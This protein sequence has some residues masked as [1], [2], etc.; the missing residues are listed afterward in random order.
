MPAKMPAP[1]LAPLLPPLLLLAAVL[2]LAGCAT[3]DH[4]P[5]M[6]RL[7]AATLQSAPLASADEAGGA[8]PAENWWHDLGDAQLDALVAEAQAGSPSLQAALARVRLADAQ[9]AAI[10]GS[11]APALSANGEA[12]HQ[13]FS[14]HHLVPRP[15]AGTWQT[16]ARLALDLN[17]EIDFWGRS[18]TQLAAA[19]A[20]GEAARIEA[21]AAR[22]LL[23]VAI[24]R[25]Y[26]SY[27]QA[28]DEL[29]LA[30]A[31]A[32]RRE[33]IAR[34]LAVRVG[35][36]LAGEAELRTARSALATQTTGVAASRNRLQA[37]RHQLAALAGQGPERGQRLEPPRL[38]EDA[39]LRLPASLPADLLARRP[40]LQA[41]RLRAE[42]AAA[43]VGAARAAFY[44]NVNLLAFAGFQSLGLSHLLDAGSH[45]AGIG[46]AIHLPLFDG[47]RLQA[48][49][50]ARRAEYAQAVA[51]YNATLVDALRDLADQLAAARA[52]TERLAGSRQA[53]AEAEA[54]EELVTT[55]QRAGLAG[56]LDV[57]AANGPVLDARRRLA[58][59]RAEQLA[60]LAGVTRA[61]G[62]GLPAPTQA[63]PRSE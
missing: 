56:R 5:A 18:G 54:A 22:Q 38:P 20:R 52:A 2:S 29:A 37:L 58:E 43:E 47:G 35:A 62:G 40:D 32:T 61:L 46:P 50:D 44:P 12:I 49:L 57:L 39:P 25:S 42:A 36:G 26:A 17:Y 7:D 3:P 53:L 15:F 9:V 48:G 4:G 34:L 11:R 6:H 24:V 14:E 30:E 1:R 55:R 41:Q 60:A 59:A 28:S 16:T 8:W 23:A 13:R 63:A 21:A 45:I 27:A 31:E 33:D 19:R 51:D 10:A